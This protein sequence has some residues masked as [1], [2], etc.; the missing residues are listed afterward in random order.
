MSCFIQPCPDPHRLVLDNTRLVSPHLCPELSLHLVT[1]DCPWWRQS[2]EDL[3]LQGIDEPFWGFAW[4]GGQ[5]LARHLLDSP[6]LVRGRRILDFGAGCGIVGLAAARAGAARV[7][8]VDIDPVCE[9][10]CRLNA[11][12]NG[13][14]IE[15]ETRDLV[16]EQVDVDLLVAGD[17]TYDAGLTARL[18]RW[19]RGLAGRGVCVLLGDPGRGFLEP[20]GLEEVGCYDAPAD[21]DARGLW[22]R[23]TRVYRVRPSR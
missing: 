7:Q 12:A 9:V 10:A 15:T 16:G 11:Q 17:M 21:N 2:P 18:V 6:G 23:P 20:G 5:A 8:A 22:L 3:E 4:A 19:F 1:E 13:L 14:T